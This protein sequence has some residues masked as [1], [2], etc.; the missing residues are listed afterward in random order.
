MNR[1]IDPRRLR[2]SRVHVRGLV[3]EDRPGK[4]GTGLLRA[5]HHYFEAERC[6][7]NLIIAAD[8]EVVH[9]KVDVLDR[10]KDKTKRV[11]ARFLRLKVWI[12]GTLRR[13]K[14]LPAVRRLAGE[15]ATQ[16]IGC[17]VAGGSAGATVTGLRDTWSAEA[18]RKGGAQ[19]KLRYHSPLEAQLWSERG[20]E[21]GVMIDAPGCA[22]LELSGDWR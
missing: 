18:A 12:A 22:Q 3:V 11:A 17:R 21:V 10:L 6:W 5:A 9:R 2:E 16:R 15:W 13:D 20:A 19:C 14:T 4:V 1:R 7:N 8:V